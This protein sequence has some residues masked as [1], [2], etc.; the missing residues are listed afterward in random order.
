MC[1]QKI[2]NI[3]LI[4]LKFKINF[5]II[6]NIQFND[7]KMIIHFIQ[8]IQCKKIL[9]FDFYYYFIFIF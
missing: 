2:I 4:K 6:I 8:K 7:F 5:F 9:Y 1:F 3:L